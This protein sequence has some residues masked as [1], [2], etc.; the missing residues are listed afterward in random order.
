MKSALI[1]SLIAST[2]ILFS[3]S[4]TVSAYDTYTASLSLMAPATDTLSV[5]LAKKK[6]EKPPKREV[7]GVY[8]TAYAAGSPAKIAEIIDLLNKTE[9]NAVVIDIKDYSGR[10]LY[11]SYLGMVESIGAE[12]DRLGN[13]R[14][15]IKQFHDNNIYVI[16]RQTVFQDPILAEKRP[17]F[18]FK[19]KRGGLWRDNLGLAW[20]NPAEPGVW[21]Y[22]TAIA[23]E[24]MKLGFDEIQFDYVRF[25]TDGNMKDIVYTH[26][27]KEK[28]EVMAAFYEFLDQELSARSAWLSVDFFGFVMERHDGAWIGQRLSDA[29]DHLDYISPMMYPSHYGAGYLGFQNPAEHP[30]EVIAYG[31]KQGMP[32]FSKTRAQVRP[33]IQAFHIGAVYDGAKIRAQIDAIEAV[34]EGGWLLWNPLSRYSAAGL[35]GE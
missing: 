33:W 34:S 16:A 11:N 32:Y 21:R 25:P 9:L 3:W 15:T 10:V 7:K 17:E 35:R 27:N 23:K 1:L 8:L 13:V 14:A 24:A 31:M 4:H 30:G 20:V 2:C 29:V 22:N 28:Y 26:G 18:A 12:D 6:K 5:V 19:N